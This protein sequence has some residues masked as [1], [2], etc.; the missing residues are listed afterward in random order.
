MA[1]RK[2]GSG[3]HVEAP[4]PQHRKVLTEFLLNKGHQVHGLILRPSNF[5]TRDDR[6]KLH[7]AD[8][9]DA[10]PLSAVYNLLSTQSDVAVSFTAIAVAQV[11]FWL[12]EA[13][14]SHVSAT[15]RSHIRYCQ[16][17][18][19][20]ITT[21]AVSQCAA[22][23]YTR[24][25][26]EAYG[27]FAC[28]AVL[29]NHESPRQCERF[30]ARKIARAGGRIKMGLRRKLVV[31]DLLYLEHCRDWGFAGDYGEVLEIG[32]WLMLQHEKPDDYVVAT[33]ESQTVEE[34]LDEAL[35]Y[36]G[37]NWGHH[38]DAR[39]ASK[40]LGWKPKVGFKELV[41]MM[42]DEDIELAKIEKREKVLID[43]GG[44]MD[45]QQQP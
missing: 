7:Y 9:T 40:V 22:Y 17:R 11:A 10:P 4:P 41:R 44:Y 33:G 25:Y 13:V 12:L 38:G 26:R 37:L 6:M 31:E 3:A 28:N 19:S 1:T 34:F 35:E 16:A 43:A 20:E 29:F 14:R 42:V 2:S 5:D 39:K 24:N 30:E 45:T 27:L 21:Y 8:L 18:S 32:M 15:G 23:W 36:A